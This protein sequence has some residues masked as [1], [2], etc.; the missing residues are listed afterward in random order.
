MTATDKQVHFFDLRKP[1]LVVTSLKN[2]LGCS[3]EINDVGVRRASAGIEVCTGDDSG[4]CCWFRLG[5][6][7]EVELSKR[8]DT[9]HESICYLT[10]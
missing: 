4:A 5:A 10:D 1:Q 3:D 2:T 7:F 6:G 8:F 9:K